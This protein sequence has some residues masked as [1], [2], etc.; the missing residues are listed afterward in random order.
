M[1]KSAQTSLSFQIYLSSLYEKTFQTPFFWICLFCF[2]AVL[3]TE[4]RALCAL[5][6]HCT[7][8]GS[9]PFI[10]LQIWLLLNSS[11]LTIRASLPAQALA[12]TSGL[13]GSCSSP[14]C[15]CTFSI[16]SVP[17]AF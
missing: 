15:T 16:F 7:I 2:Y 8:E 6:K 3:G 11:N 10:P 5:G 14:Y 9:L 13:P 12:I 17:L 4:L 1:F